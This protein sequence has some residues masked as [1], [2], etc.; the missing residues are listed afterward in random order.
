VIAD[1]VRFETGVRVGELV[2]ARGAFRVPD[3]VGDDV[4]PRRVGDALERQPRVERLGRPLLTAVFVP[5][6][7]HTFQYTA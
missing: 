5:L 6:K 7:A 4:R 1:G 3:D 2:D